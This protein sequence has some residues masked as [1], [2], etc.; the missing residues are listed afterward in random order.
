MKLSGAVE[1]VRLAKALSFECRYFKWD[2]NEED[3]GIKVI[4]DDHDYE[5]KVSSF[6]L[7]D[8][9]NLINLLCKIQGGITM[10]K[11]DFYNEN[12]IVITVGSEGF[13]FEMS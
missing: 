8:C 10:S 7:A 11:W 3:N 5:F 6:G 13:L 12:S 4:V 9:Y 1:L 2:F